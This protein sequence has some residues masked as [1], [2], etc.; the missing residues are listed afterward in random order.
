MN[1]LLTAGAIVLALSGCEKQPVQF[2]TATQM[3]S[4]SRQLLSLTARIISISDITSRHQS[5][6]GRDRRSFPQLQ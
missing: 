5:T 1:R 6:C 3:N 2:A 4:A